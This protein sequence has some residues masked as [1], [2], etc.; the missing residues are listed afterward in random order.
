M[1]SFSDPDHRIEYVK[2]ELLTELAAA[3]FFSVYPV[4]PIVYDTPFGGLIDL[5][6]GFSLPM[7]RMLSRWRHQAAHRNPHESNGFLVVARPVR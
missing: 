4:R 2:G 3:G 6:G 7:Y 5:I 1:F